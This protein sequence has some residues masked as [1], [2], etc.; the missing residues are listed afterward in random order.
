MLTGTV[1]LGWRTTLPHFRQ[2]IPSTSISSR[3]KVPVDVRR[4]KTRRYLF[5]VMLMLAGG[6]VDVV[7]GAESAATWNGQAL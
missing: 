4:R 5:A 6:L 2:A 3:A 1:W 7:G